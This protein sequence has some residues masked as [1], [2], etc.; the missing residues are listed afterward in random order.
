MSKVIF[1]T[2]AVTRRSMNSR[3]VARL[4]FLGILQHFHSRQKVFAIMLAAFSYFTNPE[5]VRRSKIQKQMKPLRFKQITVRNDENIRKWVCH[6]M[7]ESQP[8]CSFFVHLGATCFNSRCQQ[9]ISGFFENEVSHNRPTLGAPNISSH[10]HLQR[11][12][13]QE[14]HHLLV[15]TILG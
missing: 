11:F 5:R 14:L 4:F 2:K 9:H 12:L 13:S 15:H 8:R 1:S 10:L 3:D 7:S 6:S